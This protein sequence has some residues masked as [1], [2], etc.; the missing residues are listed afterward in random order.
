MQGN[1][2]K[3]SKIKILASI[4]GLFMGGFLKSL[5]QNVFLCEFY[6]LN[7]PNLYFDLNRPKFGQ[8]LKK[9]F[10]LYFLCFFRVNSSY[11]LHFFCLKV[12]AY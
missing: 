7:F 11:F 9:F 3:M 6:H 8:G 10:I 12:R 5:S 4:I 1:S 2:F